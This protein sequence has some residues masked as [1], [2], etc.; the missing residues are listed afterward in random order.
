[1]NPFL[2]DS[3]ENFSHKRRGSAVAPVC[4]Q[5]GS[6][7]YY[8]IEATNG[9]ASHI[10]GIYTYND[11]FGKNTASMRMDIF[12]YSVTLSILADSL[13]STYSSST[14]LLTGVYVEPSI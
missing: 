4:A 3:R 12:E 5:E 11:Y 8:P 14:S 6:Y 13:G 1:M 7:T 10:F 9:S 2:L